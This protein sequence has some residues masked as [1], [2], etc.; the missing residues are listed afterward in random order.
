[1]PIEPMQRTRSNACRAP[2]ALNAIILIAL[3]WCPIAGASTEDS[4]TSMFSFS[5]FGTLSA[6]HSSDDQADFVGSPI[7]QPKGA[8]FTDRWSAT[9]DSK[10]GGQAIVNFSE[11]LS[12]VVQI[13]SQYQYNGT[14]TPDLEWG[15]LKYQFTPDLDIRVGRTAIP[16][17]MVSDSLNVGYTLP[18]VRIPPEIYSQLP[19]THSDGIDGS[20]R[21]HVGEVTNTVQVFAGKYD[22]N[23]PDDGRY[24]IRDMKGIADTVE[25]GATTVH[26]SYQALHWDWRSPA[27]LVNDDRQSIASIGVNYDPGRWFVSGE[28]IRA[29]DQ[30][31]GRFYGGYVIGGYRIRKFTPYIGYS[32]ISMSESGTTG[33]PPYV[34]QST[35]TAGVRWDVKKNADLKLQLDHTEKH[36]GFQL[37]FNNQQPDFRDFGTVNL[38][39][40][41]L[42]FVF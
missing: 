10:V 42:D 14:F 25:Y 15:N 28:L 5:G 29:P 2:Y 23:M 6:V 24:K 12:A 40:I 31:F 30:Q 21:F 1:M 20:Y 16:T 17:Y 19:I 32:S 26:F 4:G 34:D 22:A 27:F 33:D 18:F 35:T 38:I 13:V 11:K 39:S 37:Y 9:P 3:L 41:A 36:G 8:G 7:V